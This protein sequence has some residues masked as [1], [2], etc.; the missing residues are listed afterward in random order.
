MELLKCF[1]ILVGADDENRCA[2]LI[3]AFLHLEVYESIIRLSV[4]A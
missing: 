1:R 3:I 2:F 4:S